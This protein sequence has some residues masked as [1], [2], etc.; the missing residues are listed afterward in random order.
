MDNLKFFF[1]N[2]PELKN[3]EEEVLFAGQKAADENGMM[4]NEKTK[5]ILE[6]HDLRK[7]FRSDLKESLDGHL[8]IWLR[9]VNN[10]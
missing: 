3:K 10:Y 5:E 2:H 6:N 8:Q 9:K 7:A 1:E 4:C